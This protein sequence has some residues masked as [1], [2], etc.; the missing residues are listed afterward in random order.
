[1]GDDFGVGFGAELVA[2]VDQLLLQADVVLDDAVVDDDDL[3]GAVAMRM[4]V[5]FRGTSVRG[6]ASVADAI[7]AVERLQPDDLFQVAQLA[8]GAAHLQAFAVT[9]D[10]DAGRVVAAILQPPQAIDDDRHDPLLADVTNN[11]AHSSTPEI[12]PD[13]PPLQ[14]RRRR[15]RMLLNFKWYRFDDTAGGRDAE[16]APGRSRVPFG[17]AA[18]SLPA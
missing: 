8:F 6:P 7:G 16:V 18:P 3:A 9:G 11:A 2:F 5:L 15:D 13:P 12:G 17:G 14:R 10:R 1:M 4:S